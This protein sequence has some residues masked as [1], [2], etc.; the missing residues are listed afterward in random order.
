MTKYKNVKINDNISTKRT[1]LVNIKEIIESNLFNTSILH[2]II[3]QIY[4]LKETTSHRY[5]TGA[6]AIKT[7]DKE[8]FIINFSPEKNPVPSGNL[9]AQLKALTIDLNGFDRIKAQLS[10]LDKMGANTRILSPSNNPIIKPT[11]TT[12]NLQP[13]KRKTKQKLNYEVAPVSSPQ[14]K[15]VLRYFDEKNGNNHT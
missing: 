15:N 7:N 13:K 10:I 8:S 6:V 12:K 9:N 1:S 3:T 14:F 2:N 5:G 4:N 11:I